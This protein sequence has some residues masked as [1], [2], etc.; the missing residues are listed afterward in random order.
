MKAAIDLLAMA[1]TRKIA[2]LGDMFELGSR[3]HALHQEVGDYAASKGL[4]VLVCVGKLSLHMYEGAA[5]AAGKSHQLQLFYYASREALI[6]ALP[7]I[8]YDNDTIL[9]KASHGM[10][11]DQVV[12]ALLKE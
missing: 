2:I 5:E 4:D 12:K 6:G 7:V 3:E 11:F 8:L 9:V 1:D 10:G